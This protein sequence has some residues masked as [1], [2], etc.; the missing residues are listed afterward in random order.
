MIREAEIVEERRI[1]EAEIVEEMR[2]EEQVRKLA[3][4]LATIATPVW[5]WGDGCGGWVRLILEEA[6]DARGL[7]RYRPMASANGG[8]RS[9]PAN[10]R[11]LVFARN[12]L[13]CVTCGSPDNLTI[14]HITPVVDGGGDNQD[15][16]QTLCRTCNSRKGAR[17]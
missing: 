3:D 4:D 12:G 6:F 11:A 16:L 15:N 7:P 10:I 14:D 1:R 13:R 17:S 9:I 8:R 2:I 5:T